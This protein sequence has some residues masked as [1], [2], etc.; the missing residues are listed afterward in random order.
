MIDLNTL[1]KT[2]N[3]YLVL[4]SIFFASIPMR[5]FL[6]ISSDIIQ[7]S[8]IVLPFVIAFMVVV[9]TGDIGFGL[10]RDQTIAARLSER[11]DQMRVQLIETISFNL[12]LIVA[13]IVAKAL[14]TWFIV[15]GVLATVIT[16]VAS[17]TIGVL[18]VLCID[19]FAGIVHIFN[20]LVTGT[21]LGHTVRTCRVQTRQMRPRL[22]QL[23]DDFATISRRGVKLNHTLACTA[24]AV[25]VHRAERLVSY[26]LLRQCKRHVP[27]KSQSRDLGRQHHT[28]D[29]ERFSRYHSMARRIQYQ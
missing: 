15:Y 14:C 5:V 7:V 28:E 25:I 8:A 26:Y 2:R 21:D 9:A 13:T 18:I 6:A 23:S 16:H 22:F 3:I 12:R 19:K 29:K 24:P 11:R 1:A 10:P 27:C 17:L 4:S 20:Y